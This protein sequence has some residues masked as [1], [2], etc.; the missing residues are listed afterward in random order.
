MATEQCIFC[1]NQAE[2]NFIK[3][4]VEDGFRMEESF[5][6]PH[7]G[8]YIIPRASLVET[9]FKNKKKDFCFYVRCYLREKKESSKQNELTVFDSSVLLQTVEQRP[10]TVEEK[11][12]KLLQF[13][14]KHSSYFGEDIEINNE[15]IYSLNPGEAS[16]IVQ[17]LTEQGLLKSRLFINGNSVSSL[18]MRGYEFIKGK[19]KAI[20]DDKCFI[21]M[22]FK[23]QTDEAFEKCISPACIA[24]GYEP[25]RVDREQYNGDIT[26]RIISLIRT[27]AFTVADFTGNRGGVYYEAGFARGLG[28]EVIMT[29]RKDWFNGKKTGHKVHFDVNHINMIQWSNEDLNRFKDELTNRIVATIGKGS[30]IPDSK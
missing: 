21:A 22:W 15:V 4:K 30:F 28:K 9:V 11:T 13:I 10:K 7:C 18:T 8:T 14:N 26:D 16:N 6:C 2:H 17:A 5:I 3:T 12:D 20:Q 24:A 29:C 27:T 25:I 1:G 19:Q 23:E